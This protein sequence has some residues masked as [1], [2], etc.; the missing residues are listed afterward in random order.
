MIKFRPGKYS[1]YVA[2]GTPLT[3]V[4]TVLTDS[5]TKE[6]ECDYDDIITSYD[7]NSIEDLQADL[8]AH[9]KKI[10]NGQLVSTSE[11]ERAEW[12]AD[13]RNE[14]LDMLRLKRAGMCF[15][16]INRGQLWYDS[17]S[18]EQKAELRLWYREWLDVTK[19]LIEP[20]PLK[21]LK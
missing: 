11:A 18:E 9:T 12:E 17:L 21:W 3:Y 5:G 14:K 20:L 4:K 6:I 16:Y 2:V 8:S 19:T 1:Q 10:M 7:Y 13:R 15:P